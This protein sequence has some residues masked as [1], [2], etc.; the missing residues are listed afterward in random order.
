MASLMLGPVTT[1]SK[2]MLNEFLRCWNEGFIGLLPEAK[3][4]L[5]LR[6]ATTPHVVETLLTFADHLFS[7]MLCA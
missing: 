6:I 3:D 2:N 5:S 7:G 4:I 1:S